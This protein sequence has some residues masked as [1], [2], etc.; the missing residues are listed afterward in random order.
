MTYLRRD[1]KK[2]IRSFKSTYGDVEFKVGKWMVET[3]HMI[4][5]VIELSQEF[6]FRICDSKDVYQLVFKYSGEKKIQISKYDHREIIYIRY[7]APYRKLD[8]KKFP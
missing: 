6:D 7:Y 1:R 4:P 2:R 8:K 5:E 3:I